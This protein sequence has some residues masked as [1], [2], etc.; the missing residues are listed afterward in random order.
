MRVLV[1]G[2]YGLIGAGVTRHLRKAGHTVTGLGRNE[3]AARRVLPEIDWIIHDMAA[4]ASPGDWL[5]A[6]EGF[7][8]V[9]NCAG[10]L[11]DGP[12]D[13]LKAIHADAVAALANACAG[14]GLRLVQISAAGVSFM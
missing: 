8:A 9:V 11:Q 4:M 3:A 6:T 2:A 10:A 7:D 14:K 12:R 1:L 13:H 5:P